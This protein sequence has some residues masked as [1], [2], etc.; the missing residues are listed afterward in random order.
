M[1]KL[2]ISYA[3]ADREMVTQVSRELEDAG[4]EVWIDTHGIQGGTLWGGEIAKAIINCD[5]LLLFLSPRSVRSD[6][7]RR[8]VDI[9]FD[10]K[11]K[12]LPIMLEKVDIPVELD[13][14]L[15]GIQ[16]IDCQ[17]SDWKSRLWS[18]LG[19]QPVSKS[20]KEPLKDTGKLK[21]PYSS[22]PVLEP[23]EG[24]LIRSNRKKELE[25]AVQH[26]EQHRLLLVT[27]MPGI[28]KSTFARALLEF[29]PPGAPLPF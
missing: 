29:M 18:A 3:H 27:G 19:A 22:L 9:A 4:H 2:F 6:Y 7:V 5:V 21:N 10:E 13:Y 20:V 17:A 28:G 1:P 8:E 11:R 14:Q 23:I 24:I 26:L 12:I 25:K 15:A 16:Y